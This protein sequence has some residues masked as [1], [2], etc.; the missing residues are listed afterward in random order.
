[1]RKYDVNVEV[2]VNNAPPFKIS[3]LDIYYSVY[4]ENFDKAKDQVALDMEEAFESMHSF[5]ICKIEEDRAWYE[6][7]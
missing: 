1:M 3:K 5:L 7:S 2:E 4:A 6:E